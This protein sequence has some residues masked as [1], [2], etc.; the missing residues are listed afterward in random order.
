MVG[1]VAESE[2]ESDMVADDDEE[3]T[4]APAL[5]N[6]IAPTSPATDGTNWRANCSRSTGNGDSGVNI[7]SLS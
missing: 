3:V 5:A 1:V 4:V 7:C 6:A 2:P